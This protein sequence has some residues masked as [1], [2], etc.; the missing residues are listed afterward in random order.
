MRQFLSAIVTLTLILAG[1]VGLVYLVVVRPWVAVPRGADIDKDWAAVEGYA[2]TDALA[3]GDVGGLIKAELAVEQE[4][5]ALDAL[6]SRDGGALPSLTVQSLPAAGQVALRALDAWDAAGGGLGEEVCAEALEGMPLLT[7]GRALLATAGRRADAPEV[8]LALRL[9]AALR[10]SGDLRKVTIGFHLA[11]EVR[12]WLQARGLRPT[13]AMAELRPKREDVFAA[14][15]RDVVCTWR[16]SR[17]RLETGGVPELLGALP[18]ELSAPAVAIPFLSVDRELRVY[19]Q[20][21]G[22]R[23]VYA[24]EMRDNLL[25]LEPRTRPPAPETLP[26][27]VLVRAT[28]HDASTYVARWRQSVE[29]Y[30]TML[31]AYNLYGPPLPE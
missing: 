5:V 12:R 29:A 30:E 8:G 6:L 27:S 26:E 14:V 13:I 21:H 18:K 2:A 22:A 11:D 24:A 3:T 16:R 4:R 20:Y 15:A 1:V 9:A 31:R 19:Q 10:G 23:L 28:I 7:L 17:T 25:R